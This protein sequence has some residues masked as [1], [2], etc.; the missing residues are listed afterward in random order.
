MATTASISLRGAG[1]TFGATRALAGVDLGPGVTGQ[2]AGRVWLADE[3]DPAASVSW[4]TGTGRYRN[5]G[6]RVRDG[7]E[8][9]E[10]SLEDAY[11]L[12]L[13]SAAPEPET[14]QEAAS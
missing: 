13:R 1:R 11:L 8:H 4:R 6:T 2:A 7:I 3:P 10:P 14:A 9:A 5:I 12:L